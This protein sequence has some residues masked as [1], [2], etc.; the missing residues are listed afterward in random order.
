MGRF[1]HHKLIMA[2]AR[3]RMRMAMSM[4]MTSRVSAVPMCVSPYGVGVSHR[5]RN[6]TGSEKE[7]NQKRRTGF[8]APGMH[9]KCAR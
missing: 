5:R 8:D 7:W 9:G 2:R 3:M 6:Q 1:R 4:L